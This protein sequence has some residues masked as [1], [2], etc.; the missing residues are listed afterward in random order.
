VTGGASP[1]GVPLVLI[2]DDEPAIT[3]AVAK[4]MARR[5]FEGIVAQSAAAA[6]DRLRTGPVDGMIVDFHVGDMRGDVLYVAAMAI[7]PSLAR[8]VV[9]VT[10]DITD[11]A[12]TALAATGCPMVPKPFVI[13]DLV[14][15]VRRVITE[16]PPAGAP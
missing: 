13:D 11:A 2:V 1:S 8:R 5:G 10:G 16:E 7:Q 3:Q 12:C 4:L 14:R 15:V 9:F 6:L